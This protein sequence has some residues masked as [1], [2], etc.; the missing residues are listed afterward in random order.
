MHHAA[1]EALG[2]IPERLGDSD[3]TVRKA[4][5]SILTSVPTRLKKPE[6]DTIKGFLNAG[7][8]NAKTDAYEIL[9]QLYHAGVF[10]MH[11]SGYKLRA[12]GF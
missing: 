10:W 1:I 2:Q 4:A 7:D 3:W 5:V 6:L 11:D 8:E 9:K 12:A